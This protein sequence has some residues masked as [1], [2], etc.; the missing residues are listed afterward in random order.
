MFAISSTA[1][2]SFSMP[3]LYMLVG[4]PGSGKSTWIRSQAF[5]SDVHVASTDDIIERIAASQGKTYTQVFQQA[6]KP[7][8]REMNQA[9]AAAFS[10]E[11]DVV[12]DQTN[13]TAKARAKKL[14]QVP[15]SYRKVALFFPTPE[16]KELQR[17]LAS[18]PGKIIPPNVMLAM[19][20]TLEMPTVDEGFDEVIVV[21]N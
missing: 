11:Q 9:I 1:Q 18:R 4:V 10:K 12:W 3:T 20:S 8:T 6:V 5:G 14:E 16:A 21:N 17:R 13:V 19:S 15:D 2:G 7:A